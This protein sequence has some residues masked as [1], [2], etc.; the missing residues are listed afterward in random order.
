M[1]I[2]KTII[3]SEQLIHWEMNYAWNRL[4]DYQSID[5][6]LWPG[7]LIIITVQHTAVL[8]LGGVAR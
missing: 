6:K 2:T 7:Y 3:S 8:A 4:Y 5:K 1:K